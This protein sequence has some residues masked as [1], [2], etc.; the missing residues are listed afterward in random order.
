MTE[1][2]LMASRLHE[3]TSSLRQFDEALRYL[4]RNKFEVE[5]HRD[6]E[7]LG[8]IISVIEP[9][10]KNLDGRLSNAI[11]I[12]EEGILS[13]LR[14]RHMNEWQ[15]Y[16]KHLFNLHSKLSSPESII[17]GEDFGILNDIADAMDVECADLFKRIG[18]RI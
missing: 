14:R 6:S 17:T 8:I 4:K 16:R 7:E 5:M 18:G 13:M 12:D 15:N 2:G 1:I 10:V 3:N 9:L 11:N